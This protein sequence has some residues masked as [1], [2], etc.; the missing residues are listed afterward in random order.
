MPQCLRCGNKYSF[1]SSM[2]P[3]TAPWVN[4]P[5]SALVANFSNE[6]IS[7]MENYGT[8]YDDAQNAW[9]HPEKYFDICNHC[10]STNILWI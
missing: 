5:R 10:G 7:N 1:G 4:G 2:L 6:G 3:Y 8:N 9:E